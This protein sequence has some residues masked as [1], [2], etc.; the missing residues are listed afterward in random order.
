MIRHRHAAAPHLR[1]GVCMLLAG[2]YVCVCVCARA[3]ARV[4]LAMPQ[5][6]NSLGPEGAGKL[7]GALEKMTDMQELSL[8]TREGGVGDGVTG[9][10]GREGG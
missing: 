6:H 7:A 9:Y 10:G 8:V 1:Q 5:H 4:S 2:V 3:C